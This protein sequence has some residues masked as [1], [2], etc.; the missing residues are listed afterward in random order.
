MNKLII[1]DYSKKIVSAFY[2]DMELKELSCSD[3]AS[4]LGGIYVG[5]VANVVNNLNACF[6]NYGGDKP[7]YYSMDDNRHIFLSPHGNRTTPKVGDEL[8]IQISKE[9]IKTKN[10]VASADLN[11]KGEYLIINL[12]GN[13]GVSNK[14]KDKKLRDEFKT[15]AAGVL[16]EGFGCIFRTSAENADINTVI[17]E[18]KQLNERLRNII[19]TA[20]TRKLYSL[21][22]RPENEYINFFISKRG[23]GLEEVVT[24]NKDIYDEFIEHFL[25]HDITDV[26]LTFYDDSICSLKAVY[27]LNK[28]LENALKPVV[29]LKSGAYL[30]IEQTE[31]MVVI[32]VNTGKAVKGK[33]LDENLY[34]VNLEAAYECCRQLRLRNLSGIIIID[35][36]NMKDPMYMNNIKNVLTEELEKD[37]V[38]A[39][40]VD[41]TKLGLVE[42][43]RKKIRKSL[44]EMM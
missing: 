36:I 42:L 18:L 9:G 6:I 3:G 11:I 35:F 29:W 24:D 31:A 40:F 16:S 22:Y 8:L 14:I 25:E 17:P 33:S 19:D 39:K 37:S 15:A 41:I 5:K 23:A 10:P 4:S 44:K 12:S 7:A 34:K 27:N 30:V 21:L 43:T 32:D 26:K 20:A 28:N 38:P 2:S 1:T 13:I